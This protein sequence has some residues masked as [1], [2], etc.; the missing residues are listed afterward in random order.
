M[1]F[2]RSVVSVVPL[3]DNRND[4]GSD[5]NEDDRTDGDDVGKEDDDFDEVD[6][7]SDFVAFEYDIISGT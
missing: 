2:A 5:S 6:N 3:C 4:V 1:D 7:L